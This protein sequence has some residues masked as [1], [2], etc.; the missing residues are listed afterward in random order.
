MNYLEAPIKVVATD[1]PACGKE[2][3]YK[4]LLAFHRDLSQTLKVQ[5]TCKNCG[6]LFFL[7]ESELSIRRKTEEDINAEYGGVKVLYTI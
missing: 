2:N 4:R 1:C 6:H 3:V 7:P 5:I